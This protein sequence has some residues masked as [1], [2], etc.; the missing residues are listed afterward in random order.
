MDAAP[1]G[2]LRAPP[3]PQTSGQWVFGTRGWTAGLDQGG[4]VPVPSWASLPEHRGGAWDP[5]D[6]P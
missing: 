4:L 5:G 1:V 2:E 6:R 3:L